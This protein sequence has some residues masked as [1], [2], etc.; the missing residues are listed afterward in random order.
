MNMVKVPKPDQGAGSEGRIVAIRGGVADVFFP[1]SVPRVHDLLFCS[2]VGFEVA[3]LIG[4]GVVRSI[5]LA[6]VRTGRV[7]FRSRPGQRLQ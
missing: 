4:G 6:P 7:R 5:A 1:D 3:A 2:D